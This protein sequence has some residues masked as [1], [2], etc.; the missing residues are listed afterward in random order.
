M[1]HPEPGTRQHG[2]RQLRNHRKVQRHAIA[3][4]ETGEITQHRRNFV[5]P[6]PKLLIG[7]RLVSLILGFRCEDQRR[8]IPVFGQMPVN[9]VVA[10][11]EL[12]AH[13]PLPERRVAGIQGGM[14]VL[15]PAQHVGIFFETLR[16]FI[17]A[18]PL[19]DR[20]IG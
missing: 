18:E 6:R 17:A 7:N 8:F 9:T 14:P 11:V 5:D 16:E 3:G 13:E 2:N 12:S 15:V 1:N 20:R 19:V 10:G 4:L